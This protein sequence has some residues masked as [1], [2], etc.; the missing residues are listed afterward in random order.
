MDS[1][2]DTTEIEGDKNDYLPVGG[3]NNVG[4]V[5]VVGHHQGSSNTENKMK[6]YKHNNVTGQWDKITDLSGITDGIGKF[7][8]YE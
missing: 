2:K 8:V 5:A 7:G 4:D 3:L 1:G 6:A